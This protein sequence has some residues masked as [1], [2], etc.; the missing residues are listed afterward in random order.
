MGFIYI[1]MPLSMYIVVGIIASVKSI[2]GLE[3][4]GFFI[5]LAE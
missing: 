2:M 5:G 4:E 1:A 3:L